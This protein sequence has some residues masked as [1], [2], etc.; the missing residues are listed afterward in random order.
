MTKTELLDRINQQKGRRGSPG[1][2]NPLPGSGT[3]SGDWMDGSEVIGD[4]LADLPVDTVL[5]AFDAAI[6]QVLAEAESHFA[7][8]K[9]ALDAEIWGSEMLGFLSMPGTDPSDAEDFVSDVIVPLV[10]DSGTESA[11]ALTVVLEELGGDHLSGVAAAARKR[12]VE[13]GVPGPA[14]SEVLGVPKVGQCWVSEDVFGDQSSVTATFSYGRR[15]HALCVLIDHS[16][17]GGV[18]DSYVHSRVPA[19][20]KQTFEMAEDDQVTWCEDVTTAD[21]ADR[22]RQAIESPECPMM[23][24]QIECVTATRALLR[25]RVGLMFEAGAQ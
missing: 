16:L 19:L 10:E 23:P 24:D 12:L 11:L 20:R 14:W 5:G 17:G 7:S 8:V 21:A 6:T 3:A 25:S 4:L 22:L 15:K 2:T 9:S 13:R 1:G 18:K